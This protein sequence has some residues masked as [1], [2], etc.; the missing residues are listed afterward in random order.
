MSPARSAVRWNV[1]VSQVGQVVGSLDIIPDPLLWK[2]LDWLEWL[3]NET[4]LWLGRLLSAR[5]I[6]VDEL[7][8]LLGGLSRSKKGKDCK[9][10]IQNKIIEYFMLYAFKHIK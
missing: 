4:W 9:L 10:H 3:S 8:Q 5:S 7:S 2:I 1:L 6:W